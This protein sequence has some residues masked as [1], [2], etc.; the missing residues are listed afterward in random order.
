MFFGAFSRLGDFPLVFGQ[1]KDHL[2]LE[3]Y[4]MIRVLHVV[5]FT[6]VFFFCFMSGVGRQECSNL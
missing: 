4:E 1:V 3:F 5:A 6:I 2:I